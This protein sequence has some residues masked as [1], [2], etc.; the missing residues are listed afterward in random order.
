[1]DRGQTPPPFFHISQT[2]GRTGGTRVDL[3]R[4][5]YIGLVM[6]L[7]GLAAWLYL[8]Q[9]TEV[10]WYGYEVR[11]L[12]DRKER[13]RRELTALRAK[14]AVAGSLTR[15]EALAEE[16]DYTMPEATDTSRRLVVEYRLLDADADAAGAL[17]DAADTASGAGEPGVARFVRGLVGQLGEWFGVVSE[18]S[19]TP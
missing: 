2:A 1:M 17:P 6:A 13:L 16:L 5:A 19:P 9:T 11:Q 14:V 8:E 18:G 7:L 15:L 4:W 10:A 3:H 12:Q